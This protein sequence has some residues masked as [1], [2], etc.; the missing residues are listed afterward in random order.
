MPLLKSAQDLME[1]KD[2]VIDMVDEPVEVELA[3]SN[4]EIVIYDE[5]P[6]MEDVVELHQDLAQEVAPVE[7]EL[8]F[9]LPNIPGAPDDAQVLE[10]SDKDLEDKK[11]E[12][13][14]KDKSKNIWDWEDCAN[15]SSWLDEMLKKIPNHSGKD[16]PGLE[17]AIAYL[18]RL[19]SEI[20]RAMQQ[21][22][23]GVIDA[24]EVA[25]AKDEINEGIVRLDKRREE[26]LDSKYGKKKKA[27]EKS[28]LVKEGRAPYVGGII[29]TVPLLI[30]RI[31]RVCI[32]GMVSAGHSIEHLYEDQV[33]KYALNEREQAELSQ[34]LE[35]MG[36]PVRTDR[37]YKRD[38]EVD[39]R[40]GKGD[41]AS[42]YQA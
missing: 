4:E 10:I 21:D 14:V 34:F 35:D 27:E 13:V 5:K 2:L 1:N 12:K 9:K 37:L 38:E 39:T 11:E 22:F 17:R 26:I 20:S 36:Y 23:E 31:A 3:P 19:D 41:W 25:K 29:V 18:K 8:K 7:V 28:S 32:N 15:F 33:K 42:N 40:D 6:E 30:S 24:D 16:I